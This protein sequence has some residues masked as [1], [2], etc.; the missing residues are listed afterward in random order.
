MWSLFYVFVVGLTSL[1][2]QEED[3]GMREKAFL[4]LG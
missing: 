3:E 4:L 2:F 1:G